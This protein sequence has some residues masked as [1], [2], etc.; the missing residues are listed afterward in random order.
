MTEFRTLRQQLLAWL[1]APLLVL[2][3]ISTSVDYDIAKRLGNLTYDRALLDAALDIGRNV[4]IAGDRVYLDLPEVALQMLSTGGSGRIHYLV[5]GPARE[6]VS[7]EPDLPRLPT[8]TT[9]TPDRVEYYDGHYQGQPVRAVGLR[10]PVQPGSGRGSV[11]IHVAEPLH[12][13]DQ[14]SRDL[15]VRVALP[16]TVLILLAAAAVWFGVGRALAP[17]ANL[18]REVE[19]RSSSDLSPLPESAAPLEALPLVRA[20]NDLLRRLNG[21]L[22]ARARFIADAAHQLRTPIAGMKTQTELA[23][24][25]PQSGEA[26]A[27]LLQ[28]QAATENATR[29]INQL[30]SLARAEPGAERLQQ[31]ARLDFTALARE[32]TTE[33]VPRAIDRGI[34][35]GFD[36][37]TEAVHVVGDPFLLRELLNNLLDNAV[38]YTTRGGQV[39]VRVQDDAD[40][41]VLLVDDNGP[42]VPPHELERV[43][44]RFYRVLGT[45]V[46]GCG[47]GLAIVREIAVSHGG[48]AQLQSGTGKA[49]TSVRVTLPRSA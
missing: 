36:E 24:R 32:V 19:A 37:R 4:K 45:G 27:T 31:R 1:A 8:A 44:E 26:R 34:D 40:A 46:D 28:L 17:L 7:G 9:P 20:L 2:W 41:A 5:L 48:S 49:G 13:R 14:F 18:R 22:D 47:L 38:R 42:G 25:Q 11:L 39:T 23:L 6:Y 35:L 33:W 43:F 15:I 10:V 29:L 16:Q 30:L 21:A 12:A 3:I